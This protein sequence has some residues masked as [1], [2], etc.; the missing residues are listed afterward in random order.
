MKK[1][2]FLSCL[3]LGTYSYAQKVNSDNLPEPVKTAFKAKFADVKKA[4]WEMDYENYEAEFKY[5]KNEMSAKFDK[6]GK[7]LETEYMILPSDLPQAV[8]E[9][10]NSNFAGFE[11]KEA[12]KV[13]TADKGILYELDI[14]KGEAKYEISISETGKLISRTDANSDEKAKY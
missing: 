7:W 1:L 6:T 2:V 14:K 4:K 10:M 11:I 9:Y 13:E 3:L 8:K 5:N 12:E